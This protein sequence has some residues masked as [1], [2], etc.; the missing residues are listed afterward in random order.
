MKRGDSAWNVK[1]RIEWNI[2]ISTI[3]YLDGMNG[4]NGY[5]RYRHAGE[6][7]TSY[8]EQSHGKCAVNDSSGGPTEM[9]EAHDGRH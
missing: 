4:A 7:V 6:H 8:L 5:P 2:E 3:T 9:A 1:V